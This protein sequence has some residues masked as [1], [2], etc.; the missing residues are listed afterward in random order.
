MK[1]V[2]KDLGE[3]AE[4]SSGGG[5][6][7]LAR[8]IVT[9]AG[10][11]VVLLSVVYFGVGFLVEWTLPLVSVEREH[12]W[13]ADL[14][15]EEMGTVLTDGQQVQLER[16]RM[17][18]AKLLE[19]DEVPQIDFRLVMMPDAE[20]NAFAIPGG[21]IAVT[22]GL[23]EVVGTD[24]IALGFVLAHELGHFVQRDHLRGMGRSIGRG[25]VWMLVFGGN[26]GIDLLS[27]R[28][29]RLLDL[30]FSRDQEMGADRWGARL[31]M[32]AYGSL[33][34]GDRLFK[35]LAENDGASAGLTLLSS[36][37]AP[38]DRV[39]MLRKEAAKYAAEAGVN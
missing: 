13:F 12:R 39:E 31:V 15:V 4:A 35:W 5:E 26:G 8:E 25:V 16:A 21:T 23:M 38:A 7:G 3:A 29:T 22:S 24:E 17:V 27:D 28:A 19:S 34:G 14:P 32:A 6:K 20:P 9:M 30:G 36:H 18:L 37:P 1:F 11:M 2:Q 10:A 33:D